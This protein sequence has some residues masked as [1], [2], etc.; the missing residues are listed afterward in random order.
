MIKNKEQILYAF[1]DELL[2]DLVM[3]G[4]SSES[5]NKNI[6]VQIE[7]ECKTFTT[8]EV[9]LLMILLDYYIKNGAEPQFITL[10]YIH[11]AYRDKRTGKKNVMSQTDLSAYIKAIDQLRLKKVSVDIKNVRRKYKV[12]NT[13]ICNKRLLNLR[14][15]M[16]LPNGDI[17]FSYDFGEFGDILVKSKRYSNNIPIDIVRCSYQQITM[18]YIMM[19]LSKLIYINQKKTVNDFKLMFT[20]IMKHIKVHAKDG[21]N[22][23]QNLLEILGTKIMNK[24]NYLTIFKQHLIN[25]LDMLLENGTIKDYAIH[26]NIDELT[27]KNYE[28]YKLQ[29]KLKN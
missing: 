27:I 14:E 8:H 24:Y 4:K 11:K 13:H 15:Y 2:H 7:S 17:I 9:F 10:S 23:N 26:P 5:N 22:T 12:N 16:R 1:H 19:Y 29:I 3:Y 21:S 18:L 20:S 28:K 6:N 25:V